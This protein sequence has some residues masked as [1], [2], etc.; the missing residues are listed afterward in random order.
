MS[1]VLLG[2]HGRLATRWRFLAL[3][4]LVLSWSLVAR[5]DDH[6]EFSWE[7]SDVGPCHSVRV[8]QKRVPEPR[9]CPAGMV[10]AGYGA[11][12]AYCPNFSACSCTNWMDCEHAKE[13]P[14]GC[15]ASTPW[16][17][18]K[19]RRCAPKGTTIDPGTN[20]N[21]VPGVSIP[22]TGLTFLSLSSFDSKLKDSDRINVVIADG[23]AP[24][25]RVNIRL[26]TRGGMWFKGLEGHSDSGVVKLEAENG[27]MSGVFSLSR[28]D[29]PNFWIVFV[30]AKVLGIH[31]PM[32]ELPGTALAPLLGKNVIFDWIAD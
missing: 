11:T 3:V 29:L 10:Q 24:N 14:W 13:F 5:A 27:G 20:L 16:L 2:L 23:N 22:R 21:P 9:A 26:R 4:V 17:P 32:Y 6:F 25:D 18:F 7:G 30:K 28:A 15:S 1:C 31:T 8:D 12:T 19:V